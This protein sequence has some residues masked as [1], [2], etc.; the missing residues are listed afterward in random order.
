MITTENVFLDKLGA[1]NRKI[2]WKNND[3][4]HI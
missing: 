3:T 4:K 1:K 2:R